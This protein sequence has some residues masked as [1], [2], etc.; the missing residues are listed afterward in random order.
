MDINTIVNLLASG[1]LQ[2]IILYPVSVSNY[3]SPE[4]GVLCILIGNITSKSF[5]LVL[6]LLS[7][8]KPYFEK[9][10]LILIIFSASKRYAEGYLLLYSQNQEGEWLIFFARLNS[11]RYISDFFYWT[12][13]V[14]LYLICFY[15]SCIILIL[16]NS[17]SVISCN[18][19]YNILKQSKNYIRF[20]FQFW[21][22][23]VL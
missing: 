2:N 12:I 19:C 1:K 6:T 7:S 3:P 11:K 15:I 5:L 18:F 16:E 13:F 14:I 9:S 20:H 23:L 4:H 10:L 17:D 22:T 8:S 21:S